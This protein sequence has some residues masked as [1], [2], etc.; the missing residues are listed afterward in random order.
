MRFIKKHIKFFSLIF[1]IGIWSIILYNISPDELVQKIGVNNGYL[2]SF[3]VA[4]AG[5]LSNIINFPYQLVIFSLGAAGLNP[6]LLGTSSGLGEFLGDSTSYLVGYHGRHILPANLQK[7][8]HRFTKWC[9]K[10][11]V[12]LTSLAIFL[13]GAFIPLPNDLIIIPLALGHYPYL[14]MMIPLALG[15]IFF[16]TMVALFG[17]YSYH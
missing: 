17:Q 3:I 14:R 15:N 13:Y 11:P 7:I 10:G 9:I 8:F 16:N 2:I 4:F 12:W 5:G 6:Y 1:F